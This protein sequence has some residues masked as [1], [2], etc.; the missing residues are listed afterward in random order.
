MTRRIWQAL[1]FGLVGTAILLSLGVWQVQRLSWKQ[2]LIAELEAKLAEPPGPLPDS[3]S[4]RA[5]EYSRVRVEGRF[6]PEE[7]HVITSARRWG[8]G[9]RVIAPFETAEGRRVL[10]DRGYVPDE[11]KDAARAPGEATVTG[12]LL[13]PDET[14]FDTPEPDREANIW[15]AR[16]TPAMA[17][18]LGTA[19]VMIVAEGDAE[20]G[21]FPVPQPVTVNVRN[22]HLQYA[23]T[24]FGLAA[25]WIVMTVVVLF[26]LHRRGTL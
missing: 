8:P 13:W 21:T 12:A 25:I 1:I 2:G 23:V 24:W 22:D 3:P 5:H 20:D 9:F 19:P 18:A 7:L 26:R 10:V 14:G 15:F 16:D 17:E 11:A 6:G 4:E